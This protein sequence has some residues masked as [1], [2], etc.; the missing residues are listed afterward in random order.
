V[1]VGAGHPFGE[2]LLEVFTADCIAV[3]LC[4]TAVGV[5]VKPHGQ[6]GGLKLEGGRSA[7]VRLHSCPQLM[8]YPC[9]PLN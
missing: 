1:V 6:G 5:A 4:C 8:R 2:S 9:T 7:G 3:L